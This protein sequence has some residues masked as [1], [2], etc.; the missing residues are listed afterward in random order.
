MTIIA[1][2]H[3]HTVAST[4][5]FSTAAEIFTEAAAAGLKAVALTDHGPALPD[6]AHEW[7]FLSMG[8]LPDVLHGVTLLRGAEVNVLDWGGRLDLPARILSQLDFVIASMHHPCLKPGLTEQHTA[9]WLAAADNP[10]VDCIGHPGQS[11]YPFDVEAVVT[12]C[13]ETDTLIEINNHSPAARPGSVDNCRDIARCCMR[14]GAMV[15]VNTDAHW[16]GQVG[17]V[18]DALAMLADIGFPESLVCNADSGRLAAWFARKKGRPL[19]A[20][21]SHPSAPG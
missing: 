16:A 20:R 18:P 13:R 21:A 5:A 4:H 2:L 9:A 3:T 10:L 6:A 8:N 11:D 1:D 12:R 19:F 17:R 7:H 15:A 14:L